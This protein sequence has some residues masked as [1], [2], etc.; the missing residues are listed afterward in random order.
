MS[1]AA[2]P[3]NAR[4]ADYKL[5][6]KDDY[7]VEVGLDE[8]GRGCLFGRLYVGAVVFSNEE[9][10]FFDHGVGLKEIKDSK[11]IS[12]RKR[13]ILNDYIRDCALATSVAYAEAAEVDALNVLQADLACMH[14]ALD[15]L[16]VPVERV[17]VDGDHWRP[18][19]DTEG[20]AIVDGDA[21]YL[22]IAA[23]GILAKVARDTWV[24][25]VVAEHPEWDEHYRLGSNMGY[26]TAAHMEGLK[27]HGATMEHRRTF[28]PVAE[29]LGLP[30]KEKRMFPKK[31]KKGSAAAAAAGT[32]DDDEIFAPRR[33]GWLGV[34]D[35]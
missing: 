21:Q 6:Y 25:S 19:K 18:Y 33:D 26:G 12:K 16:V 22:A 9:E 3:V 8:A 1:A 28:R 10:D 7:A 34:D 27:K 15:A 11:V 4:I 5:R 30:V 24:E 14:R 17:L 35:E 13:G 31:V 20:Y 23:A 32:V 2:A 29:A